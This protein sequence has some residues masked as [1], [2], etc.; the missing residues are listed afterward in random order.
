MTLIAFPKPSRP[1]APKPD[2][3]ARYRPIGI[4]A[5]LAAALQVRPAQNA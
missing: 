3:A 4:A 2:L 1:V 5:V